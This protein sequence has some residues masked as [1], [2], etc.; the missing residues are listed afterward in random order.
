MII[1]LLLNLAY[2][3]LLTVFTMAFRKGTGETLKA[4]A[5]LPF[6]SVVIPVRNEAQ[7]LPAL[8]SSLQQQDYP[9]TAV[10]WIFVDDHSEDDTAEL[11]SGAGDFRI[12]Y[13]QQEIN[14]AGKKAALTQGIRMAAGKWILTTDADCVLP[15]EW[16]RSMVFKAETEAA[17]MVCGMVA[18][19]QTGGW[20]TA[21]QAMETGVLQVSGAGSLRTGHPLLNTGTSLCFLKSVWLET[22]G[23]NA[24]QHLAS[25]DDTFLMLQLHHRYPGKVIPMI[26][27]EAIAITK[28]ADS[29]KEILSQRIRWNNKVKHYPAGSIYMTG[30]IVVGSGIG[31]ILSAF[32]SV[33]GWPPVSVFL[34]IYLLRLF[35][36]TTVL[37]V[38]KKVTGQSF[39]PSDV[40]GMSAFYPF[41]TLF[42][43]I[44][45]PFMKTAW[46]GRTV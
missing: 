2:V 25:G 26:R 30:I 18:I 46:K 4:P 42:S 11:L 32:I 35:A 23:Y 38:W 19:E 37:H 12:K 6:V 40:L 41:F 44:I 36:E 8:L 20:K 22:G 28:A 13:L 21:F 33:A 31:W 43:F 45:R 34:I 7:N 24:H 15:K 39:S 14:V 27:P 3:T 9:S 10:E 5:T 29:W 1:I 17:V 16:I